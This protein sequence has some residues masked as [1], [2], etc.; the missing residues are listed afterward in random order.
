MWK[1]NKTLTRQCRPREP[2]SD[3]LI[4]ELRCNARLLTATMQEPMKTQSGFSLIELMVAVAIVAILA[5]I[6]TPSLTDMLA[7]NR[8]STQV[9]DLIGAV[10][11]ARSE[12]IKRNQN[13]SL[14]RTSSAD[15]MGCADGG[16]WSHWIV[17]TGAGN[18]LRRGSVSGAGS[19]LTVSSTLDSARLTFASS[20]LSTALDA[21]NTLTVCTPRSDRDNVA[22]IAVGVAGRT[23]LTKS[24]GG[25]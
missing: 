15:S 17:V 23:S 19:T 2:R 1:L 16:T 25:C 13:I 5:S 12:A 3:S 24:S 7:Q 20:G 8:L 11:F 22:T 14:C 18:V 21:A 6:A 4:V 9:N 10:N